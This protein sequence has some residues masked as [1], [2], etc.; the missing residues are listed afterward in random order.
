ME[1]DVSSETYAFEERREAVRAIRTF[2]PMCVESEGRISVGLLRD[3]SLSGA[4]FDTCDMLSPF[5]EGQELRYRCG[6]DEYRSAT[7][8]WVQNGRVG[9]LHHEPLSQ[10]E[11]SPESYR[12]VRVPFS[13]PTTIFVDGERLEGEIINFAQGGLCSLVSRRIR[14][15]A[16]ATVMIGKRCFEGVATKWIKGERVG[17]SLQKAMPIPEMALLTEGR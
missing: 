5:R 9:V 3:L 12:S 1:S 7:V 10:I 6:D 16:L 17:F 13:A 4:G 11:L 14:Q 15:G 8:K 2:K